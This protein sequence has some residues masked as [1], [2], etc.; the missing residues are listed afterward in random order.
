M[1]ERLIIAAIVVAGVA[2]AIAAT[3]AG[4][5]LR[6]RRIV[7]RLRE[8]QPTEGGSGVPRIVYFT[9]TSCVVC[10]MQQ[11]PAMEHLKHELPEVVI[12]QH[13]A[14]AEAELVSEFGVL[15]VPTTAVYD[16]EGAL[17]AINRG[18]TPMAQLYAQATGFDHVAEGGHAMAAE[19][20][21]RAGS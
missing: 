21:E 19:R 7:D 3:K 6:D 16:R 1:L 17:V 10:R 14:I 12:E 18:F 9:T 11:E 8:S 5:H 20:I 15:S 13:D 2:L 4:L